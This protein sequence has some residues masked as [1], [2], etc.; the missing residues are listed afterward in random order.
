MPE[1]QKMCDAFTPH[2]SRFRLGSG[3]G[4]R[5]PARKRDAAAFPAAAYLIALALFASAEPIAAD[6]TPDLRGSHSLSDVRG[7]AHSD[8]VLH[9]NVHPD[10]D[11][12]D[13]LHSKT[14]VPKRLRNNVMHIGIAYNARRIRVYQTMC[15]MWVGAIFIMVMHMMHGPN[16]GSTTQGPPWDPAGNVPFRVWVRELQPWL[17]VTQG[18]LNPTAQAAAIQLGLRGLARLF[19]LQLPPTAI[20]FGAQISGVMADPVTYLLW[21]LGNRFEALEDERTMISGTQVLDFRGR[22]GE[23]VD[24]M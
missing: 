8:L 15:F 7:T 22:P 17:N 20:T 11:V 10:A 23:R 13:P 16:G 24:S 2:L 12:R 4:L 1:R 9:G 5:S 21:T 18:R 14:N 19:A 3:A 6:A